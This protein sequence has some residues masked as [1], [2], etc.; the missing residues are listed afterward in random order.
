MLIQHIQFLESAKKVYIVSL[1]LDYEKMLRVT[2]TTKDK[3][4]Y[5]LKCLSKY[6]VMFVTNSC[7][8]KNRTW[9]IQTLKLT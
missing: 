9:A 7:T 6:Y 2:T 3:L 4:L 8:T 1:I 5:V